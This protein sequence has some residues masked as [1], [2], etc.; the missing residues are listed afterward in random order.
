MHYFGITGE[1]NAV[2]NAFDIF[3]KNGDCADIC[4]ARRDYI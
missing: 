2:L 4:W 3:I 1:A